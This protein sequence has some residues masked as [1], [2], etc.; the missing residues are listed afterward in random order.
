[1]K[2]TRKRR[3]GGSDME[4]DYEK[5]W[6]RERKDYEKAWLRE[7]N[8]SAQAAAP[9]GAASGVSR[10]GSFPFALTHL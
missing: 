8:V 3:L 2:K 9:P 4:K 6:L 5:A 10:T 1:M 7:R